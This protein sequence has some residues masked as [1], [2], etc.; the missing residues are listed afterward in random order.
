MYPLDTL[1]HLL[2][3]YSVVMSVTINEIRELLLEFQATPNSR[4]PRCCLYKLKDFQEQ[5]AEILCKNFVNIYTKLG[6]I[7]TTSW[8]SE[9]SLKTLTDYGKTFN[10]AS[11]DGGIPD[12]TKG[13][14]IYW[15]FELKENLQESTPVNCKR[16]FLEC[17]PYTQAGQDPLKSLI[18]HRKGTVLEQTVKENLN[19]A[20]SASA[21]LVAIQ[22]FD[23]TDPNYDVGDFLSAIDR[24]G[25]AGSWLGPAKCSYA[26]LKLRG[27]ARQWLKSD[28]DLPLLKNWEIFKTRLAQRFQPKNSISE[29]F[30]LFQS[31]MQGPT[32]S[33]AAYANRLQCLAQRVNTARGI[34]KTEEERVLRRQLLE[35]DTRAQFLRG[36]KPELSRFVRVRAATLP[37]LS[38]VQALIDAASDEELSVTAA[39]IRALTIADPLAI[40]PGH[41]VNAITTQ[42]DQPRPCFRC[43]SRTHWIRDCPEPPR[44]DNRE[45]RPRGSYNESNQNRGFNNRS[46]TPGRPSNGQGY[47]RNAA[48]SAQN[49]SSN[50]GKFVNNRRGYQNGNRAGNQRG[51][52]RYAPRR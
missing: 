49:Q 10:A 21:C 46:L 7:L 26:H 34:P 17:L 15:S 18:L 22:E 13:P 39:Q 12:P 23:G 25:E 8:G 48:N 11:F 9:Q 28:P 37:E 30:R 2:L 35:E 20:M 45:A 14:F 29:L 32:E 40:N 43:K 42:S 33:A 41:T 38:D 52:T 1:S 27:A 16:L 24:A 47:S 44:S 5:H 19:H 36:L 50:R 4:Y 6:P 51:P 31:C 3:L